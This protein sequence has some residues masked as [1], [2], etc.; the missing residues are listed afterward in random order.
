MLPVTASGKKRKR[1]STY[2][3]SYAPK[4]KKKSSTSLIRGKTTTTEIKTHDL[5]YGAA[6]GNLLADA[7]TIPVI[8]GVTIGTAPSLLLNGITQGSY[9][10]QRVGNQ[11]NMKSIAV[12]AI[13]AYANTAALTYKDC[14]PVRCLL[15]YDKRTNF[16]N[17]LYADILASN[18]NGAAE[19][20]FTAM[21]N[22][23]KNKDR[24]VILK[25]KT[26]ALSPENPLIP[27]KWFKK[28]DKANVDY[29]ANNTT[30]AITDIS[31]GAL[32]FICFKTG[33]TA[34][35]NAAVI[36][37]FASRLRYYD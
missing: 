21:T 9:N 20:P 34:P 8:T 17:P 12:R 25:D 31:S 18:P 32:W 3:H 28:L 27:I 30:G 13:I 23:T 26:Y 24:F 19:Y 22:I 10:Y 11:I 37:S 1:T 36:Y 16:T 2:K 4:K 29:N 5:T 15:V 7:K 33:N 14:Q 35:D 6:T